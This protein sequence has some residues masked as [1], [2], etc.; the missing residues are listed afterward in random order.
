MVN[1]LLHHYRIYESFIKFSGFYNDVR[2]LTHF[3]KIR[4]SCFQ[5]N[6]TSARDI[7]STL[8]NECAWRHIKNCKIKTSKWS[9]W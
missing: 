1:V 8:F 7:L 2:A 4:L 3:F 9:G 6:L 5:V